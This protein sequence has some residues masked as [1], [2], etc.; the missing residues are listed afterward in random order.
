ML[1]RDVQFNEHDDVRFTKSKEICDAKV[2]LSVVQNDLQPER[3]S[4]LDRNPSESM[5][6]V[7]D[8]RVQPPDISEI[9]EPSTVRFSSRIRNSPGEWWKTHSVFAAVFPDHNLTYNKAVRSPERALCAETMNS[10]MDSLRRN[11]TWT[12]VPGESAINH[13]SPKCVFKI[14]EL[15]S[16]SSKVEQTFNARLVAT[17]FQEVESMDYNEIFA[18]VVYF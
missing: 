4:P 12:L 14:K 11:H 18:L 8:I 5:E 16:N 10:K 1:S 17:G 2:E 15:L 3:M 6:S 7:D 13:L 9:E